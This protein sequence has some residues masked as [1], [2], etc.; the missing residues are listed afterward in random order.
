MGTLRKL[1]NLAIVLL[2]INALYQFVPAYVRYVQF[3][4]AVKEVA[5]FSRD[6]PDAA[7]ADRI[8]SLAEEHRIP[9]DRDGI[10]I[11]HEMTRLAI[12]ASYVQIIRF[13]PGFEYPWNFEVTAEALRLGAPRR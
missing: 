12:D 10:Q 1:V 13:V 4:D 6:V 2:V 7:L 8:L 11:R 3:K 5:I 9:I